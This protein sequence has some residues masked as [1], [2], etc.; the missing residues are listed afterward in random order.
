MNQLVV[1][2]RFGAGS[3]SIW[4]DQVVCTGNE[5]FIQDCLHDDFGENDCT[6]SEDVGVV[7]LRELLHGVECIYM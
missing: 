2:G 3:G 7:C 4:L 1:F 5:Y 6:H